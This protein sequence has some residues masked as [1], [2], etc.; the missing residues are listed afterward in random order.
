MASER[1]AVAHQIGAAHARFGEDGVA[2]RA[3]G[4]QDARRQPQLV[5]LERVVEPRPQHLR[6][7]P[8]IFGR[9]QHQDDIGRPRFVARGLA[10]DAYRKIRDVD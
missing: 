7:T 5:K 8:V 3:A 10:L 6:R 9:A 4:G 1:H 2:A